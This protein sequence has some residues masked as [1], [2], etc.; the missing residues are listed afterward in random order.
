MISFFPYSTEALLT[1]CVMVFTC[2]PFS[3][4]MKV[5]IKS[6][7]ARTIMNINGISNTMGFKMILSYVIRNE[8]LRPKVMF[9]RQAFYTFYIH[10]YIL[11]REEVSLE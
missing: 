10:Y 8:S 5:P 11:L 1:K 9:Q 7:K 6:L 4:E 2:E 3:L